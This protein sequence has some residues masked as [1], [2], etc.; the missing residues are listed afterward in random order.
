MIR[1]NYWFFKCSSSIKFALKW[2]RNN[3]KSRNSSITKYHE[4]FNNKF[5]AFSIEGNLHFNSSSLFSGFSDFNDTFSI[6]LQMKSRH[7]YIPRNDWV[8]DDEKNKDIICVSLHGCCNLRWTSVL[9]DLKSQWAMLL[10]WREKC[11]QM[12]SWRQYLYHTHFQ[13]NFIFKRFWW[14]RWFCP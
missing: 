9:F 1:R 8:F 13:F 11:L 12:V 4:T 14:I 6:E 5:A 7:C 3:D 2:H 10:L